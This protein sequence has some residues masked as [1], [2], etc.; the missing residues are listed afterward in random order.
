MR[1]KT[2][3][4]LTVDVEAKALVNTLNDPLKCVE[5]EAFNNT[6]GKTLSDAKAET[7]FD[8]IC[9]VQ[10][11]LLVDTSAKTI[12]QGKAQKA[13]VV[14][15]TFTLKYGPFRFLLVNCTLISLR[16]SFKENC[17]LFL[18]ASKRMKNDIITISL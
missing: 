16:K 10:A 18:N 5:S 4:H 12:K 13:L 15:V 3:R 9:N 2:V 1:A 8:I 7:L 6:L 14:Y 11:K 17:E